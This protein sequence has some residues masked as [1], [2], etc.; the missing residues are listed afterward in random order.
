VIDLIATGTDLELNL[1]YIKS[2][3]GSLPN[4]ITRSGSPKICLGYST[5]VVDEEKI[6]FN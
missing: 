4:S 1:V 5:S 2:N 6:K 3:F